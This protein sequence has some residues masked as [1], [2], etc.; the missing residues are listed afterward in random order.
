MEVIKIYQPPHTGDEYV[1]KPESKSPSPNSRIAKI[2]RLTG[3]ISFWAQLV[4]GVIA[5]VVLGLPAL[6]VTLLL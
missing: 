1:R 3:W 4:L 5:A 6:V 2:F